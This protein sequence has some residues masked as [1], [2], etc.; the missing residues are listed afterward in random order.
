MAVVSLRL[1]SFLPSFSFA[2]KRAAVGFLI[3]I[4]LVVS[5]L[6]CA[7][8]GAFGFLAD[9]VLVAYAFDLELETAL[10]VTGFGVLSAYT[11]LACYVVARWRRVE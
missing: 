1:G 3:T 4:A 5:V 8:T 6:V 2:L 10:M 9:T 11:F 7:V